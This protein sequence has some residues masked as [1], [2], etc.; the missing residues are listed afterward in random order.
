MKP[1]FSLLILPF[2][3]SC[4][5]YIDK[6]IKMSEF[7]AGDQPAKHL[8]ILLSGRGATE[9]Y[10]H[11]QKWVSIAREHG[12]DVDF[13]APYAHFG[14][15]ARQQLI[16]RLHEDVILPAKRKGYETISIAGISMGGLGC[17]LVSNEFPDTIDRIYLFSPYLGKDEVHEEIKAAGGLM[18]WDIKS[19]DAKDWNY[20][21]W[22]RLKEIATD[23]IL[24]N[25]IFLAYGKQ[26]RLRG[27]NLLARAL[28][29]KSVITIPG[30]HKDVI[31][32][33]LWG[34][35]HQRGLFKKSGKI[36]SR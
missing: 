23:P 10:F 31:F 22:R 32:T 29:E 2:L 18:N 36:V 34:L 3:A 30:E 6:P 5:L 25:K 33:R 13:I 7:L 4:G 8:V 16:P 14:Y 9:S 17:L 12:S 20:F 24:K 19:N 21:I 11:D 28:P 15:Y 27:H 26:D 35:M 1:F